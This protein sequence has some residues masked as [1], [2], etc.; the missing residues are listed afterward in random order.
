MR[1]PREGRKPRPT[2]LAWSFGKPNE[3]NGYLELAAVRVHRI[4]ATAFHGEPPTSEHV[5]DHIDTNRHNNRPDNLRWLTR[6]ENVLKNPIT[7]KRIEL[8]CGSIEAFLANPALLRGSE[9][10]PNFSWMRVV[11]AEEAQACRERM[12][13]WAQSDSTP[14]GGALGE[15]VF[16]PLPAS[17]APKKKP[18]STLNPEDKPQFVPLKNSIPEPSLLVQALTPGAAQ[19]TW[20]TPCEFPCCPS[21]PNDLAG[22]AARLKERSIFAENQYSVSV[23]SKA[24]LSEDGQ[25]LWVICDLSQNVIKPW[26]L[27]QVTYENDLYIHTNLGSFFHKDGAEKRLCLAQGLEWT[28]EDTIDD[29][30]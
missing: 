1:H 14:S 22:Y 24:V 15:W 25:S 5:V 4:V 17:P 26:G 28:G 11:T 30:C 29:Y 13:I 20:Q 8:V 19:R 16:Q 12:H 7:V 2:D 10:D 21:Q 18:V 9:I 6:L 3:K 23:T 27:A